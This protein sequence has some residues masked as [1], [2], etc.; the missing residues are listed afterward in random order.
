MAELANS[1]VI[2]RRDLGA[3]LSI[4]K[5]FSNTNYIG[6][7]LKFVGPLTLLNICIKTKKVGTHYAC[8][9]TPLSTVCGEGPPKYVVKMYLFDSLC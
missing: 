7:E 4:D 5:I 9:H 1:L 8:C 2:Y 3:N 6:F